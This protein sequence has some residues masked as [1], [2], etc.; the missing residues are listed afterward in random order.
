MIAWLRNL[1]QP[2]CPACNGAGGGMCGYYEPEFYG[3]DCCNEDE[4]NEAEITRVWRWRWWGH[5]YRLWQD[6]RYYDRLGREHDGQ[7]R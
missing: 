3:C 4:D 7:N 1:I 5:R 6:E 2:V